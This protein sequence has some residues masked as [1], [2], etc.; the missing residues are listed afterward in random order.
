MIRFVPDGV[1]FIIIIHGATQKSF[2]ARN[3]I[4]NIVCQVNVVP[5]SVFKF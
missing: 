3:N 2:N 4:I 1:Y 5:F